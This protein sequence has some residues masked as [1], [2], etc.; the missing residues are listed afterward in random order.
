MWLTKKVVRILACTAA[1]VTGTAA[2]MLLFMSVMTVKVEDSSMLPELLPGSRVVAVRTDSPLNIYDA[3]YIGVGD[4]IVY[5][6]P[7]Y[8]VGSEGAYCVRRVSGVKADMIEV[9]RGGNAGSAEKE[10]LSR[11]KISGKVVKVLYNG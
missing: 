2:A 10:V 11:E 5:R 4:L 8:D 3:S 6:V 7:Y 1:A 9:S